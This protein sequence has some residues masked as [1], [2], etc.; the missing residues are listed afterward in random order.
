MTTP[1]AN[2]SDRI[3]RQIEG[4]LNPYGI[5]LNDPAHSPD[6][7]LGAKFDT[8]DQTG[9]VLEAE[10]LPRVAEAAV[11]P[12]A[13]PESSAPERVIVKP[14]R[15]S[16]LEGLLC[17][18]AQRKAEAA[19]YEQKFKDL[20]A[21]IIAE[22]EAAYP[23]PETR[24]TEAYEITASQMYPALTLQYKKS[25][26][27]PVD[28]IRDNLPQVYAAFKKLK[29]YAELRESQKGKGTGGRRK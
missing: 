5:S 15:N 8:P 28:S 4:A 10:Y 26:Y 11:S 19:E 29:T 24:P 25:W 3:N 23:D 1:D 27:L 7:L 12:D 22:L 18:Y 9:R 13:G 6:Q 17:E 16:K 21:A 14:V 2:F 20:K